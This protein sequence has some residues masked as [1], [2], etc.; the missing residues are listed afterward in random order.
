MDQKDIEIIAIS[1]VKESLTLNAYLSPF[2]NENDKEP[3]WDGQIYL[4]TK[5]G[6]RKADIEGRVS[7]QVKGKE[8][9]SIS[10]KQIKYPAQISDLK[11]YN[12]DGG[13]IFFVVY[14]KDNQNYKIY[15]DT[16]EPVE[17][18]KILHGVGE[19]QKTKT[20]ILKSFPKD[21]KAV[22]NI[23]RNFNL[24][25]KM[26]MS[27]SSDPSEYLQNIEKDIPKGKY[28]MILTGYGLHKGENDFLDLDNFSKYNRPYFY[29]QKKESGL[30]PIPLD[31]DNISIIQ[32]SEQN[33]KISIKNTVFYK[34][35]RRTFDKSD[36]NKVLV[37]F[38]KHVYLIL[39]KKSSSLGFRFKESNLLREAALDLKFV[40]GVIENKGFSM[41][42][43]WFD[44]SKSI[45]SNSVDKKQ[46]YEDS[47]KQN[48]TV[49]ALDTLGI[50]KD[51]DI[52]KLSSQ[53]LKS[54]DII[55]IGVGQN[56]LVHGLKEEKSGFIKFNFD[57]VNIVLFLYY[58]SREQGHK[59]LNLFNNLSSNE[60]DT[61][62]KT[63]DNEYIQV[64]P[65]VV[66]T[67]N[68]LQSIDNINFSEITSSFKNL[69]IT[70]EIFSVAN[71][72]LLAMLL[73]FD[74]IKH[75]EKKSKA[76]IDSA[77]D[78]ASWL[79]ELDKQNNYD[80]SLNCQVNYLQTVRRIGSL[81]TEQKK[82]LVFISEQGDLSLEEKIA[83][84][85]LLE[86]KNVTNILLAELKEDNEKFET[87][88]SWPIWNLVTK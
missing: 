2:L 81:T 32:Y 30:P 50:N 70:K 14:L 42:G 58:D 75:E 10:E 84:N 73:A 37:Y 74:S 61:V 87:F 88:K 71:E 44:F 43:T 76:L 65:F 19:K 20:I 28:K 45:N 79:L 5:K 36:K 15:Y 6:K 34:K 35:V 49:Q 51:I 31:P 13:V 48:E 11:N 26:Q 59:V 47:K 38:S 18:N 60:I 33:A 69:K 63:E 82:E 41:D 56:E 27:F 77:L 46:I 8:T 57:K 29:L 24:N 68:D 83:V 7:V 4:Y 23:F 62:I 25:K 3:S 21:K 1:K 17:L 53:D 72:L 80:S 52:K 85:I 39:N 55:R 12:T 40:V 54:L 22:R 78:L 64:S 16:L 86:S 9:E 67:A 66:L